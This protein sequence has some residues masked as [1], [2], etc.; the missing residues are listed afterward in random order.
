[1]KS[2]NYIINGIL[3]V[4]IIVLFVL[5]FTGKKGFSETTTEI[6]GDSCSVKL[7]IA[8][9]NTDTLLQNY[10]FAIDLNDKLMNKMENSRMTLNQKRQQLTAEVMEFHKKIENNAF[11]TRERAAS[12][13]SRLTK[14]TQDLN[15]EANR[16]QEEFE[17]EQLKLNQQLS[18]TVIKTLNDFNKDKKYQIILANFGTDNILIAD[19]SYNITFEVLEF[20]NQR[21]SPSEK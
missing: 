14:K 12:E 5:H 17:R 20:L 18:D 11:L 16:L 3:A 2:T 19:D 7:P 15:E 21:Y 10:K 13:E 4:A 1:M 6:I 9:V 8:F